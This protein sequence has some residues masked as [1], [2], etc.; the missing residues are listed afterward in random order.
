MCQLIGQFQELHPDRHAW[1]EGFSHFSVPCLPVSSILCPHS[2][3]E[4]PSRTSHLVSPVSVSTLSHC[5]SKSMRAVPLSKCARAPQETFRALYAHFR[6]SAFLQTLPYAF[7]LSSHRC[8]TTRGCHTGIK[9]KL[10]TKKHDKRR[11]LEGYRMK[12]DIKLQECSMFYHKPCL[13][14]VVFHV[15][16]SKET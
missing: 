10:Y 14:I 12:G 1:R 5:Y 15:L 2:L 13:Y 8:Y 3:C 11:L 16:F 9:R 7:T 4:S 6:K